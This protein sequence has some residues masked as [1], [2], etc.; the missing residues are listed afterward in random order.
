VADSEE[1]ALRHLRRGA[2]SIDVLVVDLFLKEGS[3]LRVARSAKSIR[4]TLHV[5]VLSNYAT[6]E[7]R[8]AAVAL[9]VDRVFDK[10]KQLDD[11]LAHMTRLA[12]GPEADNT[13]DDTADLGADTRPM[14]AGPL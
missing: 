14:H 5:V 6:L 12:G 11:F 1:G 8:K 9:G 7:V 13:A 4:P 2:A 10:S 3:G